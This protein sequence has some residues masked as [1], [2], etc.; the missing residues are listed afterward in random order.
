[1]PGSEDL[2]RWE[3]TDKLLSK[4]SI[5]LYGIDTTKLNWRE[6][7]AFIE[8]WE[9]RRQLEEELER[10][11]PKPKPVLSKAEEL[12][13]RRANLLWAKFEKVWNK[14][15]LKDKTNKELHDQIQILRSIVAAIG[16]E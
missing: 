15:P 6:E 12:E 2:Q 14:K 9:K 7:Q 4:L 8:T 11:N 16:G 5:M 3:E 13:Q 1:M 10:R